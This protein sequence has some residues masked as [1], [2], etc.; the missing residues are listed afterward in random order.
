VEIPLVGAEDR[1]CDY[2][3]DLY[4]QEREEKGMTPSGK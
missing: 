4:F 3:N 1:V 2:A